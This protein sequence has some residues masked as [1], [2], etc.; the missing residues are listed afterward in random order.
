MV[1]AVEFQY[2]MRGRFGAQRLD[3]IGNGHE[4][5]RWNRLRR[6][7]L[8]NG[9]EQGAVRIACAV[10]LCRVEE[11]P[12][13]AL[14]HGD[15]PFEM[16]RHAEHEARGVVAVAVVPEA[17]VKPPLQ[18]VKCVSGI[19]GQ[20]LTVARK[21]ATSM[22]SMGSSPASKPMLPSRISRT[23]VVV[24]AVGSRAAFAVISKPAITLSG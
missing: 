12:S 18:R 24:P 17:R 8:G 2:R 11:R 4:L 20:T 15:G 10:H 3:E 23:L 7:W 16:E 5:E 1:G 22:P 6:A 19:L 9:V 13:L 14:E 21:T